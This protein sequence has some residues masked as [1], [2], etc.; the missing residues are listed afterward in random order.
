MYICKFFLVYPFGGNS[1][2]YIPASNVYIFG[3]DNGIRSQVLSRPFSGPSAAP[4]VTNSRRIAN[5][6]EKEKPIRLRCEDFG[7]KIHCSWLDIK[8]EYV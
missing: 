8:T 5:F 6:E 3:L 2:L 7:V 1:I 4:R